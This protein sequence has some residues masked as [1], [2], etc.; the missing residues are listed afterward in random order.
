MWRIGRVLTILSIGWFAFLAPNAIA[1]P[2]SPAVASG[3]VQQQDP[4]P[5]PDLRD[6]GEK[7]SDQQPPDRQRVAI[8]TA[9]IVLIALVFLSRKARKKPVF[10][11]SWKK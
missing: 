5:G 4:P 6:N 10:F 11:S 8:G 1:E 3:F 7:K 2:P 9:G